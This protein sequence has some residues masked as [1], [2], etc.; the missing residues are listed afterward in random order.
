MFLA[1]RKKQARNVSNITGVIG[2]TLENFMINPNAW[3]L[4]GYTG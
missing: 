1:N 3:N 4:R 2:G